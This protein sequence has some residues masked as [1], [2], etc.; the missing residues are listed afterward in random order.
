MGHILS[1]VGGGKGNPCSLSW[2]VREMDASNGKAENWRKKKKRG[3]VA[4]F[5]QWGGGGEEGKK[6]RGERENWKNGGFISK[7]GKN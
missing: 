4:F 5:D 6:K 2:C 7:A 3:Q 1:G